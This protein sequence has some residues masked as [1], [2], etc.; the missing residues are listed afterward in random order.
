LFYA[1]TGS[2]MGPVLRQTAV[3]GTHD[4]FCCRMAASACE[5]RDR[6]AAEDDLSVLWN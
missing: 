6:V 5:E 4:S 3:E 2:T 1:E